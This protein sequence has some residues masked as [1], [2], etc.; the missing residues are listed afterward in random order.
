MLDQEKK[1]TTQHQVVV[2]HITMEQDLKNITL[3]NDGNILAFINW[4]PASGT[5]IIKKYKVL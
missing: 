2:A 3:D 1:I 5:E 4:T